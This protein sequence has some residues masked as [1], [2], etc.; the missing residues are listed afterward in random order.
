L[1]ESQE[2]GL[3]NGPHYVG[4]EGREGAQDGQVREIQA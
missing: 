2:R 4:I 3:Q 1:L